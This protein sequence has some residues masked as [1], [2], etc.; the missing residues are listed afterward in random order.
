MKAAKEEETNSQQSI[1][2]ATF[3]LIK[4]C[5]GAGVLSLPS[6]VAAIGDMP[7]A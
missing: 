7:A 6:G 5:V 1:A 3:N 2:T 4:G